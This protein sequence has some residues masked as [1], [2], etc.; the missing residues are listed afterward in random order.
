M[1]KILLKRISKELDNEHIPYMVI[2]GQAVLLYGEPR[3]TRDIDIILGIG[4]DRYEKVL[5][6]CKKL[7]LK[8]IVGNLE[9]FV[10][11]TYLLPVIDSKSGIRID[12]IFSVSEYERE[13]IG[14][15]VQISIDKT[16]VKFASLEDLIIHK[17][18]AGRARDIEDVKDVMKKNRNFDV[19]Y[20]KK[21]L[22]EFEKTTN[23]KYYDIFKKIF[24]EN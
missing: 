24:K 16:I 18:I 13:A 17:I 15:A 11:K 9:R 1:F 22:K 5:K 20:I 19:K 6:L 21:W 3:L 8:I 12:F 2:G 4:P 23:E 10:H 14:N 7:R